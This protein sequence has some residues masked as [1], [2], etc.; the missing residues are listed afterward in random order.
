MVDG[1]SVGYRVDVSEPI[2]FTKFLTDGEA[3]ELN[4]R[5]RPTNLW[6]PENRRPPPDMRGTRPMPRSPEE[7]ARVCRGGARGGAR[8]GRP[9]IPS[10][11]CRTEDC[12]SRRK[13]RKS[14]KGPERG[15]GGSE[16]TR[17]R[18]GAVTRSS[19]PARAVSQVWDSRTGHTDQSS[20]SRQGANLRGRRCRAVRAPVSPPA[21][22]RGSHGTATQPPTKEPGPVGVSPGA[23]RARCHSRSL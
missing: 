6:R 12:S 9:L 5:S 15:K 3:S 21:A 10:T 22:P 2:Q 11:W 17:L 20:R 13:A 1:L 23:L 19:G 16:G 8:A 4:T 18:G 7:T 14:N